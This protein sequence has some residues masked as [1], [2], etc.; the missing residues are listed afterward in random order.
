MSYLI[1]A[2]VFGISLLD[3]PFLSGSLHWDI[4]NAFGLLAFALLLYLFVDVGLTNRSRLH[5]HLSYAMALL[6]CA[7]ILWIWVPDPI[8]WTYLALDAPWYM[9]AGMASVGLILVSLLL[10]L[11]ATRRHWHGSYRKFRSL[12]LWLATASLIAATGHILGSGLYFSKVESVL[13]VLATALVAVLGKLNRL[14]RPRLTYL[15]ALGLMLFPAGFVL[16]K[17]PY[18]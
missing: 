6:T 18:S 14:P 8:I 9:Q 7:H 15:Q 2:L 11:P 17:L 5:Q 13:F 10:A 16:L 1:T 12:H 4:A 3:G